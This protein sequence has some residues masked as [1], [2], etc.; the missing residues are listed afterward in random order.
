[1]I[2]IPNKAKFSLGMQSLR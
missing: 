1:M 2:S